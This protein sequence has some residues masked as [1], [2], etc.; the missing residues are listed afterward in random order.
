MVSLAD[1]APTLLEMAGVP[2]PSTARQVVGA[3][4][5]CAG[6][7]LLAIFGYDGWPLLELD[8]AAFGLV[9]AGAA[10]SGL[11]WAKRPDGDAS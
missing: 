2:V 10:I 9:I 1:I 3:V 5:L 6:I 8:T 7:A 11:L 4:M